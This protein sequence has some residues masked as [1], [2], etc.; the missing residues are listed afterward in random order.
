MRTAAQKAEHYMQIKAPA[1]SRTHI[2]NDQ[3]KS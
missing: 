3:L 2:D 1:I